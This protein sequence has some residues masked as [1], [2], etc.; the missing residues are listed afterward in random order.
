MITLRNL[1]KVVQDLHKA[2]KQY[3]DEPSSSNK[4]ELQYRL[5]LVLKVSADVKRSLED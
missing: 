3:L 1:V 5:E 4:V 2:H